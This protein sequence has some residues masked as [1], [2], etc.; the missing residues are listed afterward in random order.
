VTWS[1]DAVFVAQATTCS[2]DSR[3]IVESQEPITFEKKSGGMK[4]Y[5]SEAADVAIG[6]ESYPGAVTVNDTVVKNARWDNESS[7]LL[8]TLPAGEGAITW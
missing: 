3:I 6:F 7:T 2:R 4:Y 8:L 5:L 1:N